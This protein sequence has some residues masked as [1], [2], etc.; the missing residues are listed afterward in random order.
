VYSV[1]PFIARKCCISEF[2]R[3]P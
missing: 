3:H 2:Q 1:I